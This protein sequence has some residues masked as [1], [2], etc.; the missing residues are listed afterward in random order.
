MAKSDRKDGGG[1]GRKPSGSV[2]VECHGAAGRKTRKEKGE[3]ET[4][5]ARSEEAPVSWGFLLFS[6]LLSTLSSLLLYS[7]FGRILSPALF[8]PQRGE[9]RSTFP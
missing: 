8:S 4:A 2:E 9:N 1:R 7:P 6:A 3:E 5:G